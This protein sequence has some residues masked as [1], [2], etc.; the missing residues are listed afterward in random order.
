MKPTRKKYL[1]K[2]INRLSKLEN[3][4]YR[5]HHGRLDFY[6]YLEEVLKLNWAWADQGA[7][8]T[9][10]RQ[11]GALIPRPLPPRKGRT[12]L[13]FLIEASS[14]QKPTIKNC[15]VQALVFASKHRVLVEKDGLTEFIRT[16][17]GI[18]GCAEKMAKSTK[19]KKRNNSA[20][21]TMAP[22]IAKTIKPKSDP[23]DE[24]ND[25]DD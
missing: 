5:S 19:T 15:W 20:K 1:L 7:R 21:A 25:W 3:E 24:D 13:H 22:K 11:V 14:K 12:A 23:D 16:N 18:A 4:A 17:G 8:K 2:R 9:K 6:N 10:G